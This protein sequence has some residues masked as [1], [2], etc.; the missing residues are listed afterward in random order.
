MHLGNTPV[1]P[2][3]CGIWAGFDTGAALVVRDVLNSEHYRLLTAVYTDT[4]G[5]AHPDDPRP[6]T[7]R[8]VGQCPS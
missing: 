3:Q 7:G 5:P 8:A 2:A 4:I 1:Q 6:L